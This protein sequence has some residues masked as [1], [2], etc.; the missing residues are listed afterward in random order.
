MGG[1]AGETKLV[2]KS[3]ITSRD[4]GKNLAIRL[5]PEIILTG[6]GDFD[7][8][9]GI[10]GRIK[11]KTIQ[12]K[13]DTSITDTHNIYHEIYEKSV[14]NEQQE[15]RSTFGKAEHYLFI[16]DTENQTW[17]IIIPVNDLAKAEVNRPLR[18]INPNGNGRTSIGFIIP[19][20]EIKYQIIS[21]RNFE[22]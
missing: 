12:I 5:Y 6:D 7:D 18:L 1:N 19:V 15:W 2:V 21:T 4:K 20:K 17:G 14:G 8:V 10:D 16:T 11:N 3:K 22:R 9:Q 13:Y